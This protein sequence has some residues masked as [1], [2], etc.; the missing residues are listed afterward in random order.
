MSIKQ[1]YLSIKRCT[2]TMIL[3]LVKSNIT[4]MYF[5]LFQFY[6]QDSECF[7]VKANDRLGFTNVQD[8]SLPGYA[9]LTNGHNTLTLAYTRFPTVGSAKPFDTLKLPYQFAIEAV[10]DEGE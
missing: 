2:I 3:H 4:M 6:L 10:V 5:V 8:S 1:R 9:F 7:H